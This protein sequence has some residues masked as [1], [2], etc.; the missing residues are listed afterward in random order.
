[1]TA[2]KAY[3]KINLYLDV[4]S[5][6]E[7]GFHGIRSIMHSVDLFDE[8]TFDFSESDTVDVT[9]E[10]SG[11]DTLPKD[12]KNLAIKAVKKYLEH[13]GQTAKVHM[14]LEKNIP[15]SAG[16]AGGSSDAAAAL[17]AMNR[18][19]NDRLSADELISLAAQM[20][21]DIP[22]CLL[23]GTVFCEGRGELLSDLNSPKP[24]SFVIALGEQSVSTPVA[25]SQL[26][27]LYSNF[28]GTKVS[29]GNAHLLA[30]LEGLS[31]GELSSGELFN[32]F[33]EAII[34]EL[35]EIANIKERLL[36]L[37]ASAALMSGSGPSVF[38]I[39]DNDDSAAKAE[40]ILKNEGLFAKAVKSVD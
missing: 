9:I 38:G 35:S 18:Y 5:K 3:A 24:V 36:S 19:Y 23:G 25:Y 20:G 26:D 21:S 40:Q 8:L 2:E 17:R 15:S 34:P 7:D 30:L 33:E 1:M 4:I 11:D 10:I 39:F 32:I 14:T 22:Y 27:K 31:K 29:S 28:D 12:D 16:L 37:G 6:R 13:I